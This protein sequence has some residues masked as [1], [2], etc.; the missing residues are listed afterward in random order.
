[1]PLLLISESTGSVGVSDSFSNLKIIIVSLNPVLASFYV[2]LTR[3]RVIL[4]E[5]TS[6]EKIHLPD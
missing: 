6:T 1:M 2:N 5:R 3:D 4:E